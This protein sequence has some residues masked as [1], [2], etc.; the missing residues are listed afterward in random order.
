MFTEFT[1]YTPA[2]GDPYRMFDATGGSY[3]PFV[4]HR[5]NS[6]V[7]PL[8]F[9][10][11]TRGPATDL[12]A[13][14][15]TV[16][17]GGPLCNQW[18]EDT[19]VDMLAAVPYNGYVV[20]NLEY[21]PHKPRAYS[22]RAYDCVLSRLRMARPDIHFTFYA[23]TPNRHEELW[24]PTTMDFVC[25]SVYPGRHEINGIT[26]VSR[27]MATNPDAI[28]LTGLKMQ[29][30][31]PHGET[32]PSFYA[33]YRVMRGLFSAGVTHLGFW[34]GPP[35]PGNQRRAPDHELKLLP[36]LAEWAYMALHGDNDG[37]T[38]EHSFQAKLARTYIPTSSWR[39]NHRP[40]DATNV[41]F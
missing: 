29:D 30:T 13:F 36:I 8:F 9:L 12:P 22:H 37:V 38:D 31:S 39:S 10:Y 41:P 2:Q 25:D 34:D 40:Y 32:E 18:R 7:D 20:I 17:M 28:V 19:M 24:D 15:E 26:R 33:T 11:I 27:L 4:I 1:E 16:P 35:Y 3:G 5:S 6:K 23:C 14:D 21:W